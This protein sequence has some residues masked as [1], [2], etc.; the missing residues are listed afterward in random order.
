M[1]KYRVAITDRAKND[2]IAIKK[3]GQK[4]TIRK[5][6]QIFLELSEHPY[7]GTGYP[8]PLRYLRGNIWLRRIDKKSRLRYIVQDEVV[9]VTVVSILGHYDDK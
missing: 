8:E 3:S 2:L 6:E 5:I 9:V 4:A 1:G 7:M